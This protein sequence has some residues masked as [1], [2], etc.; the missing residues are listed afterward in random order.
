MSTF[1]GMLWNLKKKKKIGNFIKEKFGT[2]V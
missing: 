2:L 1:L